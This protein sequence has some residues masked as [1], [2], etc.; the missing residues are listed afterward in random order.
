MMKR[1]ND[2]FTGVHFVRLLILFLNSYYF[3]SIIGNEVSE[4][5]VSTKGRYAVRLMLDLA[6]NNTGENISIKAVS[7]RQG[8]STKYLEQIISMLNRAGFVKSERGSGGG[9]RLAKKPEDYTVGMILRLTEGSLAPIACIEE[10][11]NQC[12]RFNQCATVDVWKKINNAINNV[13]DNITLADLV[14]EQNS[15]SNNFII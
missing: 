4:V 9:Y 12:P 14:E 1:I 7:A 8:I 11:E 2:T 13:V 15:K 10:E 5:K 3:Y 6:M